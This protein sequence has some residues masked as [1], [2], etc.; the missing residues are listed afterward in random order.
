[1]EQLLTI[2]QAFLNLPQVKMG[3]NLTEVKRAQRDISNAQKSKFKHTMHLAKCV[4]TAVDYF[5]SPMAVVI[6]QSEGISWNKE[7]FGKKVFGFQKSYF[8]KLIKASNLDERIVTA[9]NTKC[10]E[11]GT[12]SDRSLAGLLEFSRGINVEVSEG[13]T[14]EEIAEATEEAIADAEVSERVPTILTLSFKNP[15]GA[16][17]AVRIDANGLLTTR[18]DKQDIANAIAFLQYQLMQG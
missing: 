12:D 13:A 17:V 14:E 5:D 11:I 6:M 2:E 4:K 18:N 10:D 9:Y 8:Y 16:N 7:D 3:F 15:N 1:M